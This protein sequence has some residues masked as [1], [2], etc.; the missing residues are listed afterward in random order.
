MCFLNTYLGSPALYVCQNSSFLLL[1]SDAAGW[2]G[3]SDLMNLI[4][5]FDVFVKND[6]LPPRYI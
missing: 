5:A 1:M 6:T 2:G 4:D 3:E